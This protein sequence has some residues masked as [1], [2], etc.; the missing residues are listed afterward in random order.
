MRL[1][2][3]VGKQHATTVG[4]L[5]YAQI[6]QMQTGNAYPNSDLYALAVSAVVLLTGREPPEVLNDRTVTWQRWCQVSPAFASVLNRMLSIT[7]NQRYA[8]A[9]QVQQALQS[10]M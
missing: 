7:P 9:S 4:K 3:N 8:S 2:Q 1:Q 10:P 5:G 6:E